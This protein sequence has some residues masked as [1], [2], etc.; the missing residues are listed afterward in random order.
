MPA[1]GNRKNAQSSE[2]VESLTYGTG[3]SHMFKQQKNLLKTNE[4]FAF[5]FD[6]AASMHEE[7]GKANLI[8]AAKIFQK[9]SNISDDKAIKW[10]L[11]DIRSKLIEMNTF[12]TVLSHLKSIFDKIYC[13]S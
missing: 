4:K 13:N 3:G 1:A 5:A 2:P 11:G 6:I 7:G 10:H 12:F 9:L 8:A